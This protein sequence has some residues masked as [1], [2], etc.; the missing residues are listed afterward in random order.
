MQDFLKYESVARWISNFPDRPN[1]KK[2]YLASLK[3]FVEWIG[4]DPDK[5][6]YEA[7]LNPSKIH[8]QMKRYY[9]LLIEEGKSSKT[10][11]LVYQSLRSFFRWNDIVLG[12]TPR[13]FKG[14][15]EYGST[16]VLT[17]TEVALMVDACPNIR[18]KCIIVFL[19]QSGQ[20]IGVL[21]AL[22]YKHIKNGLEKEVFP[23][24]IEV[25]A[26]LRDVKGVNVNKL[27]ET[28][29][30]AVGKD[31]I[32][33]LKKMI[34]ERIENGE[35]ITDESWLFRSYSEAKTVNGK[36]IL[37][38]VPKGRIGKPLTSAA[39]R[40]I[41]NKAAFKAGIQTKASEKR[42]E[43]HP[44]IFR[45]YWNMRMQEAGLSEDLRNF[46]LGHKLPYD[47]A[48][49]KWYPDAI[50]R[51]WHTKNVEQYLSVPA[52]SLQLLRFT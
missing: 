13:G 19:A 51:E 46:M 12:R 9:N 24:I 17:P 42:Y 36:K 38:K 37:V 11:I 8:S 22:K 28:Y 32:L 5:L 45:R 43:I 33:C 4:K 15:V 50:K 41:V 26:V 52:E 39:I 47:G 1:T 16:H 40:D 34:Q 49:S 10:A 23:L 44:H 25:P 27:G 29:R 48:Y 35:K 2:S 21:T 18:D 6:V 31:T 7:K 3:K 20:R 30:F 14:R